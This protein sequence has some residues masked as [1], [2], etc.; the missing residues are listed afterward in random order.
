[1]MDQL[2]KRQMWGLQWYACLFK[3]P[4]LDFGLWRPLLHSCE[5]HLCRACAGPW[6]LEKCLN[7]KCHFKG[8]C[9]ALKMRI[10]P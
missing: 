3:L 10:F 1:M 8:Y 7:L 9:N 4:L 2:L 5:V 6:A